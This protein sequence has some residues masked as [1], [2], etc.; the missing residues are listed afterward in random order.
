MKKSLPYLIIIAILFLFPF[1]ANS[2]PIGCME[3]KQKIELHAPTL[4]ER[5]MIQ[6]SNERSDTIDILNYEISLAVEFSP[7]LITMAFF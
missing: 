4:E 1:I 5:A 3:A 6:A 2:Q 7:N